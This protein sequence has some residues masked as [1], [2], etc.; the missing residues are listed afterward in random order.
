MRR[1]VLALAVTLAIP[2][3]ALAMDS[4]FMKLPPPGASIINLSA[5][6][7]VQLPQD[8]LI[9][10]LRIEVE[11]AD[12]RD[13]Q[14]KINDSMK[15]ALEKAAASPEVKAVTDQYNIY[16][17]EPDDRSEPRPRGET[18]WR[19]TQ[20]LTLSGKNA[21]AILKLAGELQDA[22][23]LM[24]GLSYTLSTEKADEARD[25]LM[26]KTLASLM[27]R[28]RRAAKALGKGTVELVE[29]NVDAAMPLYPGPMLKTMAMG[30]MADA[31]P[32]QDPS[33]SPGE[34]EVSLTVTASILIRP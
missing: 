10:S 19:G 28:A 27:E 32:M 23:F 21:D 3:Y 18:L 24:N 34:T 5:T 8:L 33:A 26:E 25:A 2:G 12:P 11:G 1:L 6:E 16:Q 29:A 13:L 15:T 7:R 20:G 22:G 17:Y 30:E 31:Q 9:A 14:N 4:E